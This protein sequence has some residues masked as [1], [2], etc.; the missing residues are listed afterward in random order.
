MKQDFGKYASP[1]Q[2]GDVVKQRGSKGIAII[3]EIQRMMGQWEYATTEE[4]WLTADQLV[5]VKRA[6]LLSLDA[7]DQN[8]DDPE[9]EDDGLE[10]E[11]YAINGLHPEFGGDIS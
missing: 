3:A 10:D 2:I 8:Y 11:K 6:T 4:A 1:F 7:V 9:N 5:L